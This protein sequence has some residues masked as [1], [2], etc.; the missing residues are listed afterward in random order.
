MKQVQLHTVSEK[1]ADY[2][3][4]YKSEEEY[5]SEKLIIADCYN[6]I[7]SN[8]QLFGNGT[9]NMGEMGKL[10]TLIHNY[11]LNIDMFHEEAN[12]SD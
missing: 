9:E 6:L 12:R 3:N 5:N 8:A 2:V 7:V 11:Q 4:I 1:F 10:L